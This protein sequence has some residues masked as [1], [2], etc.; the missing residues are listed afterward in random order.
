MWWDILLAG[1]IS[2]PGDSGLWEVLTFTDI[3]VSDA[4]SA[5]NAFDLAKKFDRIVSGVSFVAQQMK[6]LP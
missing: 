2:S 5:L 1:M 3:G 4:T 6:S